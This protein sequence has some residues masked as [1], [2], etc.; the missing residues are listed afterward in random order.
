MNEGPS[1][2]GSTTNFPSEADNAQ[3]VS[4]EPNDAIIALDVSNDPNAIGA[5]DVSN[6]PNKT[7]DIVEDDCPLPL[8]EYLPSSP[9]V[10]NFIHCILGPSVAPCRRRFI[11]EEMQDVFDRISSSKSP[12]DLLAHRDRILGAL[13]LLQPM[14]NTLELGQDEFQEF[15][16]IIQHI[17]ELATSF[18]KNVAFVGEYA[19]LTELNSELAD[20]NA[21]EVDVEKAEK[22]AEEGGKRTHEMRQQFKSKTSALK[23]S[24]KDLQQSLDQQF[25]KEIGPRQARIDANEAM[26]P[27]LRE[28]ELRLLTR[29]R[30]SPVS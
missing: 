3:E 29:E 23:E 8:I 9:Y 26:L 14:I 18:S 19:H 22:E 1:E 28:A 7:D 4:N 2:Q 11:A 21:T 30:N 12:I 10:K 5:P 13:G 6:K 16:T 15:E 17:F 24:A 27:K 25:E 20:V